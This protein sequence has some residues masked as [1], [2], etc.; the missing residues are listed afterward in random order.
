V[1]SRSG[2]VVA[3]VNIAIPWSPAPMTELASQ[4]GPALQDAA[5]QIAARVM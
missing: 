4:H 2:D 1:R 5:R 3:A